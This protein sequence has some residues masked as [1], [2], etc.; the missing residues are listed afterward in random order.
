M[1]RKEKQ[2]PPTS[3]EYTYPFGNARGVLSS[4]MIFPVM[5]HTM[6]ELT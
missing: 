4:S 5:L 1:F 2:R 3:L 6:L